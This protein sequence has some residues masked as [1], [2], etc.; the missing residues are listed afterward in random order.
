MLTPRP[1]TELLEAY[2]GKAPEV[3]LVDGSDGKGLD[4]IMDAIGNGY[5]VAKAV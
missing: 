2:E 3:Y 1:N 5:R 4:S